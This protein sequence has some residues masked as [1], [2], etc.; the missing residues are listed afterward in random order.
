MSY[1][2][3]IECINAKCIDGYDLGSTSNRKIKQH[4]TRLP[5]LQLRSN[6]MTNLLGLLE[7]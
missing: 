5:N 4:S 1:V 3:R 7:L 2:W 6:L